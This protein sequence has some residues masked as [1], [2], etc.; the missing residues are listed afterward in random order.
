MVN[1]NPSGV[2]RTSAT[3]PKGPLAAIERLP[4]ADISRTAKLG[5]WTTL[6]VICPLS[7]ES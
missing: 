5:R 6:A 1:G 7:S 3:V 4:H 2:N